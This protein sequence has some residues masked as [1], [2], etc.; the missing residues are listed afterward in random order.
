MLPNPRLIDEV[1]S[2]MGRRKGNVDETG[3]LQDKT[4]KIVA[5]SWILPPINFAHLMLNRRCPCLK[6]SLGDLAVGF[7]LF[8]FQ[9]LV[10]FMMH[11]RMI[12]LY[13]DDFILNCFLKLR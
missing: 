7:L 13:G 12:L 3:I 10:K 1:G 2:T 4:I 11:C 8:K 9:K 6:C 5:L